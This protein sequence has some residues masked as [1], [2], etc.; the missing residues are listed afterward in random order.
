MPRVSNVVSGLAPNELLKSCNLHRQFSATRT[1]GEREEDT[2]RSI[3]PAS[4]TLLSRKSRASTQLPHPE[5]KDS[6]DLHKVNQ[7]TLPKVNQGTYIRHWDVSLEQMRHRHHHDQKNR[8]TIY[9]PR[10]PRKG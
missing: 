7:A 8:N 5:W 10:K 6:N 9:C 1:K 2:N 3:H 4:K